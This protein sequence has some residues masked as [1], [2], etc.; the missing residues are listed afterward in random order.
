MRKEGLLFIIILFLPFVSA[1]FTLHNYSIETDYVSGGNIRGYINISLKDVPANTILKSNFKGNISLLDFLDKNLVDY[2]CS[3]ENCENDYVKKTGYTSLNISLGEGEEKVYGFYLDEK[4]ESINGLSFKFKVNNDYVCL[5]PLEIDI[6]NDGIIE[7][8]SNE[9]SD[10]FGCF[11]LSCYEG[12][13]VNGEVYIGSE[14]P[15]CEKITLTESGKFELGAE[16]K[17]QDM[18]EWYPGLLVMYLYDFDYNEVASCELPEPN[19]NYTKKSCIVELEQPTEKIDNFYVCI[20][21]EEDTNYTIKKE[22]HEPCGFFAYPGEEESYYDYSIFANA[23]LFNN[24]G[25]ITFNQEEYEKYNSDYLSDYLNSYIWEK[26][27]EQ[28]CVIPIKFKANTDLDLEI[29]DISLSYSTSSGIQTP[30]NKIYN[31]EFSPSLINSS[32]SYLD[33]SFSNIT[34]PE[35]EGIH[36]FKLYF[37]DN[38]IL[39]EEIAVEKGVKIKRLYPTSVPAAYPSTFFIEV[40]N[41][42]SIVNYNWDFGD[43]TIED[44]LNNKITHTYNSIGQYELVVSLTDENGITTEKTFTIHVRNPK[45]GVNVTI[46]NY[47]KRLENI[48][49]EIEEFP[50]WYKEKIKEAIGLQDL[51]DSLHEIEMDYQS[52]SSDEEYVNLMGNLTFLDIPFSIKISGKMNLPY[53][54][55]LDNIEPKDFYDLGAGNYEEE[56]EEQYKEAIAAWCEENLDISLDVKYVTTYYDLGVEEL[57][58]VYSLNI[59][60]ENED[61]NKEFYFII[62]NED[63]EFKDNKFNVKDINGKKAIDFQGI[64]NKK[65]EFL[66][67]YSLS[68]E[69]LKISISPEF[70]LLSLEKIEPCDFDGK[71]EK[72][73]GENTRNCRADCKPWGWAIFL[74]LLIFFLGLI[75]YILLQLWYQKKYE[76]YLFK[77]KNDLYNLTEFIKNAKEKGMSEKEIKDNLKK[78]GWNGEQI[79]YVFKKL[80]GESLMPFDFLKL[81]T[82]FKNKK[83]L[84]IKNNNL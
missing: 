4:V 38:K 42:E 35:E 76:E 33:L 16:I 56:L 39:E 43:G 22:N 77:N 11:G 64:S 60:V 27:C 81:F 5:N 25:E 6:L 45:E 24:I 41:N 82:G 62:G 67:P 13:K 72:D 14:K 55:N 44:T 3:F 15:Y 26:D 70:S 29:K 69:N 52:A 36:T 73:Q 80:A 79:N 65:I 9:F 10:V 17:K 23:A 63:V 2:N 58:G 51:I 32:Y 37:D 28:G 74:I 83:S 49:R 59:N 21:A 78:V 12:D 47:K 31:V 53:F 54:V 34:V 50:S 68:P 48:S 18:Q 75:T 1:S 30:S 57:F 71:C 84:N 66:V 61:E 8:K 46:Q 40:E 20:Q 7:W 19:T